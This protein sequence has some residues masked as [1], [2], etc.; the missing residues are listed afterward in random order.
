MISCDVTLDDGT[1]MELMRTWATL[2]SR[3]RP[4]FLFLSGDILGSAGAPEFAEP[5]VHLMQKPVDLKELRA[6]VAT[7]V[8]QAKGAGGTGG[9]GAHAA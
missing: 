4:P 6:L 3:P 1:S 5:N 2:T 7:V 8:A 9:A